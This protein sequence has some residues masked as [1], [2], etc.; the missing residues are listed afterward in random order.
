M[1]K[2]IKIDG[3]GDGYGYGNSYGNGDGN[4]DGCGYCYDDGDVSEG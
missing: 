1:T 3:H 2:A 4:G